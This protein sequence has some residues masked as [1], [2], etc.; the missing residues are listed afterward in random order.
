[1]TPGGICAELESSGLAP[2]P[3]RPRFLSAE[4]AHEKVTRGDWMRNR[5]E[6]VEL[7]SLAAPPRRGS[8]SA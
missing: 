5:T 2:L 4:R 1:M 7:A 3:S 6:E 8:M